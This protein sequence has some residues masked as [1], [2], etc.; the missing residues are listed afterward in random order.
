MI[1]QSFTVKEGPSASVGV[2]SQPPF[3][4][5]TVRG[6]IYQ[7]LG[8]GISHLW[9]LIVTLTIKE[10]ENAKPKDKKYKMLDGSVDANNVI[11]KV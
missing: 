3:P 11:A 7:S 5:G 6:T 2:R 8:N 10:I 9:R 4:W 1:F